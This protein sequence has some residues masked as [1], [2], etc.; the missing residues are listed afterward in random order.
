MVL[1]VVK[2][3]RVRLP[4]L[5]TSIEDLNQLIMAKLVGFKNIERQILLVKVLW[6]VGLAERMGSKKTRWLRH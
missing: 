6:L 2:L 5:I 3:L 1:A 4:Q